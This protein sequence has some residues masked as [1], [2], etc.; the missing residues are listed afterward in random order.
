MPQP[1]RRLVLAALGVVLAAAPALRAEGA[2][3]HAASTP[4]LAVAGS[5]YGTLNCNLPLK[6][7]ACIFATC[8]NGCVSNI[9]DFGGS[10]SFTITSGSLFQEGYA[11][12]TIKDLNVAVDMTH[13]HL[14]DVTNVAFERNGDNSIL[15]TSFGTC[16][17][18]GLAA[19]F[20]DEAGS[21][22]NSCPANSGNSLRSNDP[23]S[24]YDNEDLEGTYTLYVN[25]FTGGST[26][27]L[28][29]YAI[30]AD[31]LCTTVPGNGANCTPSSTAACLNGDRFKVQMT[32]RTKQGQTGNG[33][34][35]EL[36]SDT[37]WFWFFDASNAEVFVKVIDG[38]GLNN[39][40]WVFA[41]G[42]TNVKVDITV[43]DT[44][45]GAVRTYSNPLNQN[46]QPIYDTTGG[47]PCS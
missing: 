40:Y 19:R 13:Q 31:V 30:A 42:L 47:F 45:T 32:Y 36:T 39:R 22:P 12:C 33:H 7:N 26:G 21:G 29:G 16:N 1:R 5:A 3:V 27:T 9:P 6:G 44:L 28:D 10:V 24:T 34:A 18:A 38:C 43:T 14:S 4:R 15:W 35:N 23:L 37:G 46:F 41:S 20:D 11:G 17:A 2:E 8:S 25:D